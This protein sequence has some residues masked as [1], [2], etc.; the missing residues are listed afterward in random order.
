MNRLYER[1]LIGL[2]VLG[3]VGPIF[4]AQAMVPETVQTNAEKVQVPTQA[5][6]QQVHVL[7]ERVNNLEKML[8]TTL[9][10]LESEMVWPP[11]QSLS[12]DAESSATKAINQIEMAHLIETLEPWLISPDLRK[13]AA[14]IT[15]AVNQIVKQVKKVSTYDEALLK[16]CEDFRVIVVRLE[17]NLGN[18]ATTI[19]GAQRVADNAMKLLKRVLGQALVKESDMIAVTAY[20]EKG[21]ASFY[22]KLKLFQLQVAPLFEKHQDFDYDEIR[23]EVAATKAGD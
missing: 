17:E 22:E 20:V 21:I 1:R 3:L 5:L 6:E 2:L 14:V 23:K 12:A 7:T 15:R 8:F 19:E 18:G 16:A 13:P 4:L 9:R 10:F 11:L